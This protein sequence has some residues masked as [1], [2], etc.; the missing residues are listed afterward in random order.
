MLAVAVSEDFAPLKHGNIKKVA[1]CIDPELTLATKFTLLPASAIERN[2][3]KAVAAQNCYA[4]NAFFVGHWH[5]T[6][7]VRGGDRRERTQLAGRP[8]RRNC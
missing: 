1:V 7:D 8:S 5:L 2:I 4:T 6:F 3:A